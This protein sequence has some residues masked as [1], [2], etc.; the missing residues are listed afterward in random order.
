[1]FE[2]PK[3]MEKWK[4]VTGTNI[5]GEAKCASE[6]ITQLPLIPV[7]QKLPEAVMLAKMRAAPG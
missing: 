7:K 4:K 3:E 2:M 5:R 6:R 1:M